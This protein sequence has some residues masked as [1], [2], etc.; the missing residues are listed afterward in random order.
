MKKQ[1]I[2]AGT[3]LVVTLIVLIVVSTI[4]LKQ[5]NANT[6]GTHISPFPTYTEN[7]SPEDKLY[8]RTTSPTDGS[9]DVSLKPK[10]TI[11]FSRDISPKDVVLSILPAVDFTQK[12]QGNTLVV[13]PI[14][15]LAAGTL[16]TYI[17][18]FPL[19]GETSTT[20][21]FTTTG[22]TQEFLPDTR[23]SGFVEDEQSRSLHS[24]PDVYVSNLLPFSNDSFSVA[25]EF[26]SAPTGHFRIIVTI[27][28]QEKVSK[29]SFLTWLKENHLSDGDITK[30]DI[31]YQ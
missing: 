15:N 21:S 10:I 17:I 19:I 8:V 13:E 31:Q 12:L 22:L 1:Y 2:I 30:L 3:V 24:D 25:S 28:G 9:K 4:I 29:N 26:I 16:Y 18:K 23:P 11:A 7:I 20:H 14:T 27:K 6:T 5:R